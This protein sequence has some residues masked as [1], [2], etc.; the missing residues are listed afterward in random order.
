MPIFL[1]FDFWFDR[2]QKASCFFSRH[3]RPWID[4]Q[5]GRWVV[6]KPARLNTGARQRHATRGKLLLSAELD[7][8]I[9]SRAHVGER[10]QDFTGIWGF[11]FW[12]FMN[13]DLLIWVWSGMDK[14]FTSNCAGFWRRL[15]LFL[16]RT[17]PDQ[18]KAFTPVYT[19][20]F[21]PVYTKG[22]RPANTTLGP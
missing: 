12:R 14:D 2:T 9:W 16:K 10:E 15:L 8:N 13:L 3:C 7:G 17:R 21:K 11:G 6:C 18:T 1:C 22:F 4:R 19:K 5:G 20:A